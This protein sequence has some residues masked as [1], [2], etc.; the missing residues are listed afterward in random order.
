MHQCNFFNHW[1]CIIKLV[2]VQV[3]LDLISYV[4]WKIQELLNLNFFKTWRYLWISDLCRY[5]AAMLLCR[6]II[7]FER[8]KEW[9]WES[10]FFF[11]HFRF[12]LFFTPYHF[13]SNIS[14]I[15]II[16]LDTTFWGKRPC[17]TASS[18]SRLFVYPSPNPY[19]CLRTSD[20]L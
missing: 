5:M 2:L 7:V 17:K 12:F 3:W 6:K 8:F 4:M 9:Y 1:D 10:I 11:V 16:C 20:C 18:L 13:E 19:R 15:T 14:D